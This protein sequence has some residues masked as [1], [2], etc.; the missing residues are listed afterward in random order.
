M[1]MM[2]NHIQWKK[3]HLNQ[4]L[5]ERQQIRVGTAEING[6]MITCNQVTVDS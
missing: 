1:F 6:P 2:G 5:G 4:D 3:N